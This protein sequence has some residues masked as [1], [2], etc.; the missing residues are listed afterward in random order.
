MSILNGFKKIKKYKKV[1]ENNYQL[2]SQWTSASTVEMSD[3]STLQEFMDNTT[4]NKAPTIVF[5][6]T[7]PESVPE[8]TIVMVYEE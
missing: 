7:E 2:Q 3:G 4:T 8:N 1:D 5:S 6:S